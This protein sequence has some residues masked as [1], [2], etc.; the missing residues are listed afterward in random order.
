[1]DGFADGSVK[2]AAS[3]LRDRLREVQQAVSAADATAA[4]AAVDRARTAATDAA[5][6]C[7]LPAEQFL[8]S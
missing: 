7:G 1:M 3:A 2:D 5:Q 6:A 8:G 4:R